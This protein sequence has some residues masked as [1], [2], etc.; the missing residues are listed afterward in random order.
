VAESNNMIEAKKVGNAI[1][2]VIRGM[3]ED[4]EYYK[5]KEQYL[6]A[7]LVYKWTGALMHMAILLDRSVT[8][9]EVEQ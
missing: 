1:G 6:A 9:A 5:S 4:I 2:E 3:R 7:E 8:N